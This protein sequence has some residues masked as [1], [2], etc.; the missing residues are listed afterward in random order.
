MIHKAQVVSHG[1]SKEGRPNAILKCLILS[2]DGKASDTDM[3]DKALVVDV[4][5]TSPYSFHND[6]AF[7]AFPPINTTILVTC[8]DGVYY[9]MSSI[10]GRDPSD[11][12]GENTKLEKL[13]NLSIDKGHEPIFD[14]TTGLANTVTLKHPAGHALTMKDERPHNGTINN[15]K[16]ELRSGNASICS[17]DDSREVDAV[18]LGVLNGRKKNDLD[19]IT[20]SRGYGVLGPRSVAVDAYRNIFVTSKEGSINH[21]IVDGG[22]WSVDNRS[23]GT[24]AN[25]FSP[26]GP[27]WGNISLGSLFSDINLVVGS[28]DPKAKDI[29]A[30]VVAGD[31]TAV[32]PVE[33]VIG[34]L[35][36]KI[37]IENLDELPGSTIRITSKG[38]IEIYSES[39]T[40]PLKIKSNMGINLETDF[41]D[42]NLLAKAGNVNIQGMQVRMNSL[43][44]I[45]PI[46]TAPTYSYRGYIPFSW[47]VVVPP[48]VV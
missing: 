47:M 31:P 13:S 7:I 2:T 23:I 6:G 44:P 24:N 18:R 9:Y 15:S 12:V 30:R 22:N 27:N 48:G 34:A 33:P 16:L 11:K 8:C 42:I 35:P 21:T 37:I 46:V 41:G 5:Y 1:R 29:K 28:E 39:L 4:M 45:V 26:T 40:M 38:E 10:I 32:P 20:I 14:R 36:S 43:P 17:L 25:M 19:G 3:G